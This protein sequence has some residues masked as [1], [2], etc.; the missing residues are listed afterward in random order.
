[1]FV[2]VGVCGPTGG[3][4]EEQHQ[5]PVDPEEE[6]GEEGDEGLQGEQRQVDEDFSCDVEQSDGERHALPH[7][8]H[9]QQQDDLYTHTHT[10]TFRAAA[11][12][13]HFLVLVRYIQ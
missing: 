4:Q 13:L 3:S 11:P 2:C 6:Q 5:D 12:A 9:Q 10:Q 1:M 7:E 8:E